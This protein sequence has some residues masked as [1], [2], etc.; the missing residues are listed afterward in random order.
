MIKVAIIDADTPLAG[1]LIRLLVNHPDV[2]IEGLV[3]PAHAGESAD[4]LH[5]GL[6]GETPLRF[7]SELPE[8]ANALFFCGVNGPDT[9]VRRRAAKGELKIIDASKNSYISQ[10]PSTAVPA[11]SEIFRKPLVRGA[12]ETRVFSPL[13]TTLLVALFPLARNLLLSSSLEIVAETGKTIAHELNGDIAADKAKAVLQSIQHSFDYPV[14]FIVKPME[15]DCR[16]LRLRLKLSLG[17]P[18]KDLKPLY[19]E[20]YD[21]HNFT[22]LSSEPRGV[23]EVEGTNKCLI[24]LSRLSPSEVVVEAV[25]DARLRGGAGD[26][27]LAMNLMFGLY[28]RTGL[29]LKASTY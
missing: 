15:A 2:D 10:A 29:Q 4:S 3:S 23:S 8:K 1:E 20:V 27:V 13:E 21:D 14:A 7:C 12:S 22:Y 25:T 11:V 28:E 6:V 17:M 5:H 26:A 16:G 24:S 9:T 19:E 18:V